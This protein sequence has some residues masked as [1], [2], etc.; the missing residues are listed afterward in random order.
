MEPRTRHDD[1]PGSLRASDGMLAQR[2]WKLP[3]FG[4]QL[5]SAELVKNGM[6]QGELN[7]SGGSCKVPASRGHL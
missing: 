7:K 3:G 5:L 2:A 4:W 1:S 6:T